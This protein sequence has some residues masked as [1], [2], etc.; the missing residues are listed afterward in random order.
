MSRTH[1]DG[2]IRG[3][4][5]ADAPVI[6]DRPAKVI[7]RILAEA[8]M[9]LGLDVAFVSEFTGGC[10]VFRFVE[11]D[12]L[13][14][15][16]RP[17]GSDPCEDAYC[18]RIVEGRTPNLIHDAQKEPS[19]ADMPVTKAL[20]VGAHVSVP[21]IFSDGQ[22]YGT[23]CC[24][25]QTPDPSLTERDV[26][27]VRAMAGLV[28]E[29]LE[30]DELGES[31]RRNAYERIY[32]VLETEALK[33]VFQPIVDLTSGAVVGVEALSRFQSEPP[34]TPDRWFAEAWSAGLGT[35]LEILA[36]VTA[37]EQGL[38]HLG[39]HDFLSI[40]VSP[41]TALSPRL[42]TVL[43]CTQADRIV[44]ELTEHSQV[45]DYPP[46]QKALDDIR[47]IGSR[48]AIDDVGTGYSGLQQLLELRPD[49]LK[50]DLTVT[51]GLDVDPVR[52]ALA[53][54]VASFG[55]STGLTVIAEGIETQGEAEAL[56]SLDIAL[57]QG[58]HF[59]RPGPLTSPRW[60]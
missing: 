52:L 26:E 7:T 40:N 58:Y 25:S 51:R 49:I 22:V 1:L 37:I 28:T 27:M 36:L 42:L 46:L 53:K 48:I 21:I 12:V 10:R 30:H 59:G 23:F 57:G 19:V 15:G 45:I 11:G 9:K 55:A 34:R 8:R 60:K 35:E 2:G 14:V 39:P 29:Q 17:G 6:D 4:R 18:A 44:L 33:I 3:A 50:L 38:D 54:A 41:E 31:Q 43:E 47:A 24:F 16:L 13:A 5:V 56:R 20:R 32:N